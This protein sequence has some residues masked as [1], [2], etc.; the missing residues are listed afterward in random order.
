MVKKRPVPKRKQQEEV[1]RKALI[2]T[3]SII[4]AIIVIMSILLIVNG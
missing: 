2:W 4:A 1:N 3:G